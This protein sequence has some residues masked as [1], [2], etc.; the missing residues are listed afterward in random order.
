LIIDVSVFSP[1]LE[2]GLF[3]VRFFLFYVL[4]YLGKLKQKRVNVMR[5]SKG[6]RT[7]FVREVNYDIWNMVRSFVLRVAMGELVSKFFKVERVYSY[8]EP[9][10]I[11]GGVKVAGYDSFNNVIVE[12]K[13]LFVMLRYGGDLYVLSCIMRDGGFGGDKFMISIS[14]EGEGVDVER[15]MNDLVFESVENSGYKGKILKLSGRGGKYENVLRME[16]VDVFGVSLDDIFLDRG[17]RDDIEDFIDAVVN[18][19]FGGMKYLFVGEPGTGKTDTIKAVISHCYGR[20]PQITIFLVDG[21]S[22]VDIGAL[23]DYVRVFKP[24]LVCIDDIDLMVGSRHGGVIFLDELSGA[25]Q[26][27]DG[28]VDLDGLYL[29]ATT[30]DRELVDYA[31]RRPGRFDLILEFGAL[32]PQFYP[33]LVI[34]EVGDEK[35]AEVFRD[36]GVIDALQGSTG[37]FIVNLVKYLMRPRFD[38]LRY[39]PEFVISVVKKFRGSFGLSSQGKIGFVE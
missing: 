38:G 5:K 1:G 32:D 9:P 36:D 30:N 10:G 12:G 4:R 35:L 23:F 16:R 3:S 22:G 33:R 37:A 34:R 15:L 13:T 26:A 25:L 8:I 18:L 28:F 24:C 20:N 29:I 2:P 39:D 19:R 31:V 7:A 6:M 14:A 27:L 21:G 17:M 11:L